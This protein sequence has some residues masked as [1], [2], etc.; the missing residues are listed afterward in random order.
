MGE[1]VGADEDLKPS[2]AA[3]LAAAI[4]KAS[5]NSPIEF[6]QRVEKPGT[7]G[8]VLP[9]TDFHRICIEQLELFRMVV[10]PE[11]ILSVFV[12][13]AGSYVMDQLEL[14]RV[15]F[16][17]G[18]N[19]SENAD[20][21][22]LLGNFV[23]TSGLRA[24]E[25][26]LSEQP[27]DFVSEY[28]AV[29]LPLV[30]HPFVV[31]FLV[32]ELPNLG[33]NIGADDIQNNFYFPSYSKIQAFEEESNRTYAQFT[34]EQK[35]RAVTIS[36]SIAMAY[37]MD[38]KAILLQQSVWQT[39][40]RMCHLVEQ[41]RSS[42][43]SITAFSKMLSVHLK[44]SEISYDIVQDILLHGDH[45]TDTLQQLQDAV[46]LT[47]ANIVHHNENTLRRMHDSTYN[48][49]E[50]SGSLVPNVQFKDSNENRPY[51]KDS[52]LPL[53]SERNDIEMP[54]PP[55]LLAPLQKHNVRP[56]VVLNVLK[57]LVGAALPLATKQERYLELREGIHQIDVAVEESSLRQGL[58][59]LIEGALLRTQ[60]GGKVEIYA[61]EAPAGGALIIIDDNGPDMHYMTQTHSLTSFGADLF[62]EGQVADSMTWNFV[63]GLAVAREILESY[64]CVIRV[65]SPRNPDAPL[66]AR[67]TRVEI[68]L[69]TFE[70]N[71]ELSAQEA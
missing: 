7:S 46:Y 5:P 14:R 59:N 52:L 48:H 60:I 2:S 65:V 20:C 68:W 33:T 63:A 16:Y 70:T 35:T 58:S 51:K 36:R 24:A 69:P 41:I 18:Y 25:A 66:D 10:H 27:V 30:K 13:P 39:N 37:V 55:L 62:V 49:Q 32:A 28:G 71:P 31:G 40:V 43:S 45:M 34:V 9:S 54:M 1:D 29:I 42:L 26:V 17:P 8:I 3:A 67:G 57:D 61:L 53:I 50:L 6:S 21:V 15:T 44:R 47:K 19:V 4:R 56:C 38:Q 23:V 11:A 22:I 64:G 12:R